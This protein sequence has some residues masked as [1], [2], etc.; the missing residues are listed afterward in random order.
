MGEIEG[1]Q[2]TQ[3]SMDSFPG[4]VLLPI[5]P[6]YILLLNIPRHIFLPILLP[7]FHCYLLH[8]SVQHK[9]LTQ[10]DYVEL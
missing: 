9:K 5:I 10:I 6:R 3:M 7:E 8:N 1:L 4:C 2:V